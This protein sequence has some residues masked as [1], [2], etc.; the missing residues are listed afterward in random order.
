MMI[1]LWI[2]IRVDMELMILEEK[3]KKVTEMKEE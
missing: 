1:E 3:W 2:E